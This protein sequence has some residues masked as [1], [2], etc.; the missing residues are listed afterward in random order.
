MSRQNSTCPFDI[1]DVIFEEAIIGLWIH[2][3]SW[4]D[5]TILHW[6]AIANNRKA[7]GNVGIW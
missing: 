7:V 1:K 3:L 6:F 4:L 5:V 2:P